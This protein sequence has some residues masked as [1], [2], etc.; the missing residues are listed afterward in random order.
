MD[1]K[2]TK[3]CGN[4]FGET[5]QNFGKLFGILWKEKPTS[6]MALEIAVS[7]DLTL[8]KLNLH[9]TCLEVLT[10]GTF[11]ALE[12]TIPWSL[13]IFNENKINQLLRPSLRVFG[14]PLNW[15][16]RVTSCTSNGCNPPPHTHTPFHSRKCP[17]VPYFMNWR[18]ILPMKIN[19]NKLM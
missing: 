4:L 8:A 14:P 3:K 9:G 18:K 13:I 16:V 5:R 6:L 2:I 1:Y 17:R 10:C 11:S 12:V 19:E 15:Y 7:I